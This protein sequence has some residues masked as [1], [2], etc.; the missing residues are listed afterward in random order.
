M[1]NLHSTNCC[2]RRGLDPEWLEVCCPSW[3]QGKYH[4]HRCLNLPNMSDICQSRLLHSGSRYHSKVTYVFP[5]PLLLCC[6][7][8][9]SSR[10]VSVSHLC[11]SVCLPPYF[12]PCLPSISPCICVCLCLSV[13]VSVYVFM[14]MGMC[15]CQECQCVYG[16]V[17]QCGCVRVSVYVCV[18]VC[19]CSCWCISVHVSVDVCV[20]Q[21]VCVHVGVWV[22]G[23]QCVC[24]RISVWGGVYFLSLSYSESCF[25]VGVQSFCTISSGSSYF[26]RLKMKLGLKDPAPKWRLWKWFPHSPY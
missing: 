8:V 4:N 21:C 23:C 24:V 16:C 26:Q 12:P 5:H 1:M 3:S 22:C 15:S 2:S 25:L 19:V 18:L 13:C 14:L 7:Q 10:S 20:C 6:N 11:V 9:V 17:Y